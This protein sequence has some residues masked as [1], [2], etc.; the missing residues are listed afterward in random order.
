M[1]CQPE[2]LLLFMGSLREGVQ[3]GGVPKTAWGALGKKKGVLGSLGPACLRIPQVM[4]RAGGI[5]TGR[6][7][8]RPAM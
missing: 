7:I 8:S 2:E 3:G 1:H 6:R 5:P 4:L